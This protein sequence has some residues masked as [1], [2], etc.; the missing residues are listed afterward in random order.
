MLKFTNTFSPWEL[1]DSEITKPWRVEQSCHIILVPSYGTKY[2]IIYI[3]A[4]E[5]IKEE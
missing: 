4:S 2:S 5:A 3:R 1:S